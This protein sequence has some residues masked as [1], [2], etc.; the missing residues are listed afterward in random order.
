MKI[1]KKV[2]LIVESLCL[3]GIV[4]C[5]IKFLFPERI[6]VDYILSVIDVEIPQYELISKDEKWQD[7]YDYKISFP[8][9]YSDSIIKQFE[10][11]KDVYGLW[12]CSCDETSCHLY[13]IDNTPGDYHYFAD[14]NIQEGTAHLRMSFEWGE[15]M[16]C[17]IHVCLLLFIG[18]IFGVVYAF[19]VLVVRLK[20]SV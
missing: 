11:K 7:Y 12:Q 17:I 13:G 18:F 16:N 15:Q 1:F 9:D 8:T 4:V 20:S 3:V 6:G 5:L 14:I 2:I 19:A 10:N